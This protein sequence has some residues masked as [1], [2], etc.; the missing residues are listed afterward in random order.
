MASEYERDLYID[1]SAL[2]VEWI[3]QPQLM[4]K[5]SR[6]YAKAER[7]VA[8]MKEKISVKRA[9]LDKEIRIEP[10]KFGL[11]DVKITEAVV[12][13]A[14][15]TDKEFQKLTEDLI[16]AN[17]EVNMLKGAVDAVKQRKDALQD[18]VKLHG[19]QYFAGPKMP[20]DLS[21]EVKQKMQK[22]KSNQTIKITRRR[23]E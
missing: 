7:E 17:Y 20:R 5:Y 15:I 16:E 12:N 9:K 11:S 10:E 14:I 18:L 4:L 19:Q 21:F 1:E 22:E 23:S 2:D 6:E 13:N 8:R 3:G